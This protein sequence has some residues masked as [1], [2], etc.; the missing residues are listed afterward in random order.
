MDTKNEAF[1]KRLLET[2]FQEAKEHIDNLS[3]GLLNLKKSRDAEANKVLVET[4]FREA[5]SFKGAARAV[6]ITE[7]EELCKAMEDIFSSYKQSLLK[8]PN[9]LIE[10]MLECNDMLT[11]LSGANEDARRDLKPLVQEHIEALHKGLQGDNSV[12][13]KVTV[14]EQIPIRKSEEIKEVEQLHMPTEE[15]KTQETIR[16]HVKKLSSIMHQSEEMLFAK[17]VSRRHVEDLITIESEIEELITTLQSSAQELIL[18][19]LT[20]LKSVINKA[21]KQTKGDAREIGM[22]VDHLIGDMKEALM[23]P[24]SAMFSTLP[25]IV[26]DMAKSVGK[27]I[28]L[29]VIGG[30]ME[31]DRRISEQMHDPL[32]HLLRN[33]ID[34]GI[35][36]SGTIT[37]TLTQKSASKVELSVADD[38]SGIDSKKIRQSS[39]KKGIITQVEADALDEESVLNL[40]FKS[41]ISTAKIVTDLSGRGLGLAI[42]LEKAQQFGGE[43]HVQNNKERGCTFTI[44]LP[45]TMATFRGVVTLL[46]EQKFIFASERIVRVMT[47]EKENIKI[48]EGKE[49]VVLTHLVVPFYH[50]STLLELPSSLNESN[51]LAVVVIKYANEMLAVGVDAVEYEEEVMVKSLGKQLTRVHAISGASLLASDAPALI[52]NIS[53]IFK[54]LSSVTKRSEAQKKE[55]IKKKSKILVVD[56]SSTTLALLQNILEMVGYEVAVAVD[57]LQ[58]FEMLKKGSFDLVVS[59]VDMPKMNGFELTEAIRA[60]SHIPELPVIL[61]TSLESRED[62]ERG[63]HSGANAYLIKSTFEQSNLIENIQQLID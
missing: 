22:M 26:H 38:G 16:I 18:K 4:L 48:V 5:H 47:I 17:M 3:E 51:A 23:L 2:F 60:D 25:K 29:S 58:A 53:D 21:T 44:L 24:F 27:D 30:D 43:V 63:M 15:I 50:L 57:G 32:I 28:S 42:V 7:I 55:S 45:L 11:L 46:G 33:S 40:I 20:T 6:N 54:S 35:E 52:L 39:V 59:D 41:G 1:L 37:L 31:I 10:V 62:K 56:D 34:H 36:K 61:V 9:S 49:M 14:A 13:E 19:R 8:I 12:R